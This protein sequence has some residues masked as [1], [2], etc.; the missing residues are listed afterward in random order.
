MEIGRL[1]KVYRMK[2]KITQT[3]FGRII[4]VNKQTVSKWE[5]G[6]TKPSAAKLFEVAAAIG[7][8]A[9]SMLGNENNKEAPFVYERK[10]KYDVGLNAMYQCVR[11]FNSF[12]AFIDVMEA[13]H[14]LLEPNSSIM[15]YLLI[16]KT[17]EDNPLEDAIPIYYI[18]WNSE[19][20]I[21]DIPTYTLRLTEENTLYVEH[22][23][24][25]NNEVYAFNV[26][27]KTKENAFIQLILG[28]NNDEQ[29]EQDNI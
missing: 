23:D 17:Y 7:M 24:S 10:H 13:A 5:N 26:Y 27:I 18:Y 14:I 19:D 29:I 12:C 2:N 22:V 9:N 6:T 15:G 4:G 1:I 28:F 3:A 11:D 8:S 20:I 21:I 25:F 16:D